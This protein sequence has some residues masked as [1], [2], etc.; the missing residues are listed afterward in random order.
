MGTAA[1]I[2]AGYIFVIPYITPSLGVVRENIWF[3]LGFIITVAL[4]SM[5]SLTDSIFVAYRSAQYT[6]ITDGLVSAGTKLILPFVFAG[7]GAY[8]VFASSGLA[9]S[10]GMVASIYLLMKKFDYVPKFEIDIQTL[11]NVFRYAFSNYL[12]NLLNVAPS[13]VLPILIIGHLGAATAGYFYL[14]F[15]FLKGRPSSLSPLWYP[16][17]LFSRY[18]AP[19]C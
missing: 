7:L 17:R 15:N 1:L 11:K 10:L 13:L 14:S 19:M 3:G 4:A 6:L 16:P 5:N 9:V 2:A 12:A 18:L 8:G